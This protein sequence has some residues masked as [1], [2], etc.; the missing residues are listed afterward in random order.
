MS[1]NPNDGFLYGLTAVVIVIVIA[2]SVF[3]LARAMRRAR[4]LGI[5]SATLKNTVLSSAVF[6]IAPSVAILLG[7]I[8]LSKALGFPFPWL[9]LSV[10]G[11]LTYETTA[12]ASAASAIGLDLSQLIDDPKA[13]TTI[14]W[15]M[16]LGIIPGPILVP[17]IGKKIE[18]GV[19][20]IG[21]GD[22][23]WNEYFMAGLFLGMISAFLGVVFADV[24][25]GIVGWI[26]VF[27]MIISALLMAL[28]GAIHKIT[29]KKWITDY[30]LPISMLGAMA[31]AIPLT[32]FITAAAGGAA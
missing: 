6:T 21:K 29:Q 23:K 4:Q 18:S 2:Q 28:C 22:L 5:S 17:L 26:P 10:I 30:A 16:T 25:K 3:F 27:V 20:K 12:A 8:A 11:A 14:A 13:F 19:A 15:V 24:T 9:R 7:V 31:L 1:F 32:S